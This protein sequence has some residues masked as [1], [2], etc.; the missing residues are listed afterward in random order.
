MYSWIKDGKIPCFKAY[1]V[2]GRIP[3]EMDTELARKIGLAY[4]QV[5]GPKR[6][7]VGHDVR[8]SCPEISEALRDGLNAAGVDVLTIGLC[9][10]EEVYFAT[11]HLGLDGG[12]MVTASHNPVDYNGMKFVREKSIPISSDTGLK[13]IEAAII[14]DKLEEAPK[15]G[16]VEP[17]EVREAYIE[18]L[19]EYVDG[20]RDLKPLKVVVNAGN[21]CAGPVMDLLEPRLPF[22]LTKVFFEPDGSFPNGVPNPLLPENRDATAKVIKEQGADLGVAWDGDFDR[23][24]LFD[25]N[26]EFIEGYYIV[27]LLAE[28]M[29]KRHSGAKIIHDPRLVWNT[30]EVVKGA[31]GVPVQ[32]KSGHAFIKERMRAEDAVYGGEMSAHHY[33]REFS[34]C[35]SGMVPWMLVARA[36]CQRGK[37]LSELVGERIDRYPASGEIN[38]RVKDAGAALDGVLAHYKEKANSLDTTDGISLDF[39]DWRFNLRKSNTEPVVRLNVEARD[40]EKLMRVR[41]EEVLGV[42][43]RL[44]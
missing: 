7:V 2:R 29:L 33:F 20:A 28:Q 27:G 39:G 15:R 26:A 18:H 38:R 9:G 35:D 31:G 13:E 30:I 1:D 12:I 10:T 23:C 4:A 42:L 3:D 19:M 34:Y 40:D 32:C 37:P 24:F 16:T 36:I 8:L 14:R 6:V 44:S 41:T 5:V 17:V 25:E 43:E 11:S 21:G 22:E